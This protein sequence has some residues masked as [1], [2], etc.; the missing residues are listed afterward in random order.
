[1]TFIRNRLN[2]HLVWVFLPPP[3]EDKQVSRS[4]S[5]VHPELTE[6]TKPVVLKHLRTYSDKTTMEHACSIM[7]R[8]VGLPIPETNLQPWLGFD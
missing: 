6:H 7:A 3:N 2:R 4:L 8:S 5:E 1:M